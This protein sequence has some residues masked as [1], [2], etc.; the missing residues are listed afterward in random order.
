MRLRERRTVGNHTRYSE[1]WLEPATVNAAT[2][3]IASLQ[4]DMWTGRD[5][6]KEGFKYHYVA[7]NLCK[8]KEATLDFNDD[9]GFYV[10]EGC[11]EI[12][13]TVDE[14]IGCGFDEFKTD[15]EE[16]CD[17]NDTVKTKWDGTDISETAL[18]ESRVDKH[19]RKESYKFRESVRDFLEQN[20]F[21]LEIYWP[22]IDVYNMFE[23][24][25]RFGIEINGEDYFIFYEYET[26][27]GEGNA[28]EDNVIEE[29][30]I[31]YQGTGFDAFLED[32]ENLKKVYDD[33]ILAVRG[34]K[35]LTEGLFRKK[36][37]TKDR[38]T[39]IAYDCGYSFVGT[40]DNVAIF[41]KTLGKKKISVQIEYDNTEFYPKKA[42]I[43]INSKRAMVIVDLDWET[44]DE[45]MRSL[46]NKVGGRLE[47][48]YKDFKPK[49]IETV[50]DAL[51]QMK[52]FT[53]CETEYDLLEAMNEKL[54]QFGIYLENEKYT[55][56]YDIQSM[57]IG[58]YSDHI[59]YG[60]CQ[61]NGLLMVAINVESLLTDIQEGYDR[62]WEEFL[63]E[64]K[65]TLTHEYTHRY[66][67]NKY[68][69]SE[70]NYDNE[71]DYLMNSGEMAAR[72]FGG[73]QELL[74]RYKIDPN[75]VLE[76]LKSE[77][78]EWMWDTD[79]LYPY[80]QYLGDPEYM[81]EKDKKNLKRLKRYVYQA[82]KNYEEE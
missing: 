2:N 43:W 37:M 50:V 56:D 77:S 24:D 19:Y 14:W 21:E 73:V 12:G 8:W 82:V 80:S 67:L 79:Q 15:L 4:P 18:K 52:D 13:D 10:L 29:D 74:G 28:N 44:T 35:P 22:T 36:K 9:Y 30:F 27:V 31:Y 55:D 72:A 40:E 47:E 11:D 78:L 25:D 60:S 23:Q 51:L 71:Y 59:K 6:G 5:F 34:P 49:D 66:Q 46:F 68:Q 45:K 48:S 69:D 58:E 32:F 54:D 61:S 41:R 63:K 20:G 26:G 76:S 38:F 39:K 65:I 17:E 1:V 81:S 53:D 62:D 3:I 70:N 16:F 33:E 42:E 64:L 75:K 57:P 7:E